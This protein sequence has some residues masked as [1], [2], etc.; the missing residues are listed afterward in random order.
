MGIAFTGKIHI[1]P[2]SS[3]TG[4]PYTGRPSKLEFWAKYQPVGIDSAEVGV[5]LKKWNGVSSDTVAYG[6]LILG[7]VAQYTLFQCNLTYRLP[8]LS[9]SAGI[10]LSSSL[11]ATARVGSTLYIDD[12]AF[13]GWVGINEPADFSDKVKIFPNPAKDNLSIFAKIE[14]ADNVQV[15][16]VTGKLAGVYKIQNYS[17]NINTSVFAGGIY[18]YEIR[19]KINKI[20]TNGKFSVVE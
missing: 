1:N 13:T 12:L 8:E 10:A 17:A 9:D 2:V 18:F 7:P 5:L 11:A 15:V 20:L 4:Y 19:D 14:E 3:T 16:D 6:Q